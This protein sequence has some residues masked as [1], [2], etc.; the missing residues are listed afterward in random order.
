M[1]RTE[2][3]RIT[4][5]DQREISRNSSAKLAK[6]EKIEHEKLYNQLPNGI[7]TNIKSVEVRSPTTTSAT[8]CIPR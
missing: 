6:E 2:S 5:G 8:L 4:I 7:M 3:R 1:A